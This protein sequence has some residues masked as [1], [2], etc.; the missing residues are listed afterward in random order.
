MAA[1]MDGYME[2]DVATDSSLEGTDVT[3]CTLMAWEM[4]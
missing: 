1:C 2:N 3:R 4:D